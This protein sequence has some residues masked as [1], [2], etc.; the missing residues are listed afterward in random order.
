M[1][2]NWRLA[3]ITAA[4]GAAM[5]LPATAIAQIANVA[6]QTPRLLDIPAGT[7]GSALARLGREVNSVVNVDP[8][9]VRGRQSAGLKGSYTADGAFAALLANSGLAAQRD[10]AGGYRV[11]SIDAATP[12]P[13]ATPPASAETGEAMTQVVVVGA[14]TS[15]SITRKDI[16]V[17]QVN[18]LTDLFRYVPSVTVGGAV[19]IAQKIYVRGLE[20]HLLNITVDGAPQRGTLF[21]HVGRVSIE[22]DLLK[23][24]DVQTGA[25]EATSG[26]GAIG[27]AIRFKTR[28]AAD[29]LDD[30]QSFGGLAKA[31]F[32]SNDGYKLSG[33]VFGRLAGETGFLASVVH[34]ERDDFEDGGGQRV[35][36]TGAKQQLG[37][38]KIGGPVSDRQRLSLSYE[39]RKEK[40]SFGQ[41][42]N[43]PA[44]EGDD[45]FPAEA[46]RST[47][48]LNHGLDVNEAL[49]FESTLYWTQSE[50]MQDRYDSWGRYGA[51]ITS[52]GIDLRGNL[53]SGKHATV[54]GVEYRDD[55]V[56]SAYLENPAVWADHA[57]DPAIGRFVEQ[58]EVFGIYLQDH[59]RLAEPL[60]LSYGARYDSYDLEQVTYDDGARSDGVSVN[61]GLSYVVARHWTLNGS[62]AQ[63]FRGKEI[64][65]AF[66]LEKRPGRIS[67]APDL[68]PERVTNREIGVEYD[69]GGFRASAV[70]Y[71][72]KIGDVLLDQIGNGPPPQ[73]PV[74]YENVG[75]FRAHGVELQAGYSIGAFSIDGYFNRFR[76]RLNEDLIEGYEHIGLGNSVGNNWVVSLEYRPVETWSLEASITRFEDLDDIEVLQRGVEIGWIGETQFVDKP[77]YTLVDIFGNWKP[78]ARV[79]LALGVYNLFDERYRAHASVADYNH[80]PGW[81][82]VSGV[83]EPGRNVRLTASFRF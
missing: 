35:F 64:G 76:S 10:G 74:Y 21:H 60:L 52:A 7:L 56:A 6:S 41:R 28:D 62:Y 20:D 51:E 31:G 48:V 82:G 65:D 14:L 70:Y 47:A 1:H 59:W 45:L 69:N 50:F 24:V 67:L 83:H 29:L 15:E 26:F 37:F 12:R 42:P 53:K 22:P 4:L 44:M 57:W 80:I 81:E 25:G 27:G 36:G 46:T 43:W 5:T 78:A 72:M 40:A 79:D 73:A 33:S 3:A 71:R 11:V 2:K 23:T 13:A 32:F 38:L 54:F 63:A 18:D 30:G 68:D 9:L 17:R 58:G 49:G 39:H 61:A 66:T 77:G 75:A 34:S 19:G 8:A 16:E 55:E